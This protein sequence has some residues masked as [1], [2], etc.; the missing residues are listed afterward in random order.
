MQERANSRADSKCV[1]LCDD[2]FH[3]LRAAEFK[4]R[5]AGFDVLL[6]S[7]GVD[8]LRVLED[9][10]PDAVV[11]DCQMPRMTGIELIRRL[12]ADPRTEDLPIVMLTAKGYEL[13]IDELRVRYKVADVMAKPFSP[14]ELLRRVEQ[15]IA[16]S[17]APTA[18][19]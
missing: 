18:G 12:R 14:R 11:T 2:E 1:L 9:R 3:I 6:A 15:L 16:E 5:R 7:D 13:P 10:I 19:A 17:P 4:F 8:A